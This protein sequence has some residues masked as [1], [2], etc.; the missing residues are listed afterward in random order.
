MTFHNALRSPSFSPIA[1]LALLL[2][3]S[4]LLMAPTAATLARQ[5]QDDSP[6]ELS[7]MSASLSFRTKDDL[8]LDLQAE[9]AISMLYRL[10]KASPATL[11]QF[12]YYSRDIS[13]TQAKSDT[14]DYRFWLFRSPAKLKKIERVAI[15]DAPDTS[16]SIQNFYRCTAEATDASGTPLHCTIMTRSVPSQLPTD[17]DID[18]PIE[19][20][21]LLYNRALIEPTCRRPNLANRNDKNQTHKNTR[22]HRRPFGLVP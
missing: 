5:A 7:G 20:T 16:D 1:R 3:A 21:G 19:F 8:P 12:A 18:E 15:V 4:I 14:I 10:R 9:T 6:R 17:T 22:V 13:L 11:N 2:F